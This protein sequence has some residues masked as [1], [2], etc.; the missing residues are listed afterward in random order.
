MY[1]VLF[2]ISMYWFIAFKLTE[3]AAV[4]LP[5]L[6]EWESAYW[7][8]FIVFMIVIGFRIAVIIMKIVE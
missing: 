3:G 5:S 2:F 6:D 1:W 8:F 7:N 4:L